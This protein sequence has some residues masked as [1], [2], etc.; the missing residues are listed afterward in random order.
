MVGWHHGLN[1]HGC[2][3][4]LGVG[5]G[6]ETLACC[7]PWG[8]RV[9]HNWTEL[10]RFIYKS[11]SKQE[12]HLYL[13]YT[14]EKAYY[15]SGTVHTCSINICPPTRYVLIPCEELQSQEMWAHH[16]MSESLNTF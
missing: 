6:Q 15:S 1:G 14:Y 7:S 8:Y 4:T 12:L 9:G 5:V 10:N 2:E 13:L 16:P 3:Q 11:I